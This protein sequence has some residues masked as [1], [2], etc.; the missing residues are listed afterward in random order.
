MADPR[1]RRAAAQPASF[2]F[3]ISRATLTRA[4]LKLYSF[5]SCLPALRDYKSLYFDILLA[6]QERQ[7]VIIDSDNLRGTKNLRLE[8]STIVSAHTRT[9]TASADY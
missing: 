5:T 6:L 3:Q 9:Q 1:L 8:G 7:Q 2:A 4:G